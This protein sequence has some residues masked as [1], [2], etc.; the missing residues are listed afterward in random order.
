MLYMYPLHAIV[1]AMVVFHSISFW[2]DF[3]RIMMTVVTLR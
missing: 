1:N 3:Y 2:Y